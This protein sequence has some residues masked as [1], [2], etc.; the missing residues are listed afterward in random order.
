[1]QTI[2]NVLLIAHHVCGAAPLRIK[3][4]TGNPSPALSI[5]YFPSF[6]R[7]KAMITAQQIIMESY[8]ALPQ[9]TTTETNFTLIV[10]KSSHPYQF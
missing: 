1:M 10:P 7:G 6:T 8:G 2:A 3:T 9:T 4:E 5:V